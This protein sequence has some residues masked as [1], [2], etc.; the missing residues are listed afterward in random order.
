MCD[1]RTGGNP[2]ACAAGLAVAEAFE[3]EGILDNVKARGEQFKS[4]PT[5]LYLIIAAA[6]VIT[7]CPNLLI[8][9]ISIVLIVVVQNFFP[10]LSHPLYDSK[11]S[12]INCSCQ[13]NE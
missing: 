4:D 8:Y 2:L 6:V 5:Y 11:N 1:G 3:T 9:S 7:C 10:L 13:Q 12:K